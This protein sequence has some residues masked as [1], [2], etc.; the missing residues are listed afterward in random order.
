MY[1]A[2]LYRDDMNRDRF[3]FFRI[4][5]HETDLL[6]GVP[7]HLHLKG[8]EKSVELELHRLRKILLD[9]SEKDPS[10]FSSHTPLDLIR[11]LSKSGEDTAEEIRTMIDCG[12][13][14]GTGPMASVA[15]LFA[16]E[17]G[18]M[19]LETYGVMEVVVENGG[20]LYLRNESEL[21]SVIHA[22]SSSLSDKMAFVIPEGE[23]G[24]CTSSGTLGHSFSR[25]KA[26]AVTIISA[27]TPISDAWATALA[28]RVEGAGDMEEM[29]ESLAGIPKIKGCAVIVEEQ[30]GIR[31]E[32]ELKLLTSDA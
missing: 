11:E 25:G 15:G 7:H 3:R 23:W 28:N 14:T 13:R 18:K 22:G 2:R 32:I 27:S 4:V 1:Q 26:D 31:G 21:L 19:L 30:V 20:D 17:V 10:F 9:Y 24:V 16:Q 12:K 8:I 29:L 6:I 5:H